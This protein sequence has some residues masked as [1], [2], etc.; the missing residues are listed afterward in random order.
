MYLYVWSFCSLFSFISVSKYLISADLVRFCTWAFF[1]LRWVF[2]S[3]VSVS[4]YSKN[5]YNVWFTASTFVCFSFCLLF[6]NWSP[7]LGT[8]SGK[9]KTTLVFSWECVKWRWKCRLKAFVISRFTLPVYIFICFYCRKEI[10]RVVVEFV[11]IAINLF[12]LFDEA[13]TPRRSIGRSTWECQVCR[14]G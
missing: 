2:E 12:S 10:L 5:A 1:S 4:L 6:S 8:G 14:A 3:Q 13:E 7:C 11:Q 9:S